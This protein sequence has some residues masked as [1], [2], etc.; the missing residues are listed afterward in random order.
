M[1]ITI[2]NFEQIL[3]DLQDPAWQ[4]RQN[5]AEKLGQIKDERVVP[6]LIRVLSDDADWWVRSTAAEALG[7]LQDA[8]VIE[9]LSTALN[10]ESEQVRRA[11]TEALGSLGD[12]SVIPQLAH[13]L[14][15]DADKWVRWAAAESLGKFAETEIIQPLITALADKDEQV[16]QA[17]AKAL[18]QLGNQVIE[19]LLSALGNPNWTIRQNACLALSKLGEKAL[20]EAVL[21]AL[22]GRPQRCLEIKDFR[23][24]GPLVATVQN[25]NESLKIRQEAARTLGGLGDQRLV[26]LFV[27]ILKDRDHPLRLTAAEVLGN[28]SGD[29]VITTLITFLN[30][31]DESETMRQ[32]VVKSLGNIGNLAA[33]ESLNEIHKDT[34][35]GRSMH[36]AATAATLLICKQNQRKFTSSW[37][38]YLC[39]KDLTRFIFYPV[40]LPDKSTTG[41]Y[42]CR[43]CRRIE[44]AFYP[45]QVIV[46]LNSERAEERFKQDNLLYVSWLKRRT[47]FD[48]D[49]VKVERVSDRDVQEFAIQVGNDTDTFR[50]SRYKH[51]KCVIASNCRLLE[52][53]IRILE[54]QFG[55]VEKSMDAQQEEGGGD[56]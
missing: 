20:G 41:Y 31:T 3:Q 26:Q 1:A 16:G 7:R 32:T 27:D 4:K 44:N 40:Y 14:Q 56:F 29:D 24:I 21:E 54:S 53:T 42:A 33:L 12:V 46:E 11:A 36:E 23:A 18:A 10:D 51:M 39:A 25:K 43:V 52:N 38:D 22:R 49:Q 45:I 37:K 8:Q 5:A 17:A 55:S 35:E 13:V 6:S 47:L 48:F 34:Q 15:K 50:A 28:L 19:H 30:N 9:H 2:D